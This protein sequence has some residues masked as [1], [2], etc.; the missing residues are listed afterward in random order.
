MNENNITLKK[1]YDENP[2]LAKSYAAIYSYKSNATSP[3]LWMHYSHEQLNAH[4]T[5]PHMGRPWCNMYI[6]LSGNFSFLID[7]HMYTP[8]FGDIVIFRDYENYTTIFPEASYVDYYQIYFPSSFFSEASTGNL[9]MTP[10]YDRKKAERNL[11]SPSKSRHPELIGHLQALDDIYESPNEYS[12]ILMYS[13]II[14]IM[15]LVHSTF[16]SESAFK[17]NSK[18]PQKLNDAII[19]IHNSFKTIDGVRELC[20]VCNVSNVYLTRV[21]NTYLQCTPNEY[22]TN[23]R[24][25]HAKYLL[26]IGKSITEACFESGFNNYTY[27]ISKFKSV[28]GLTPSKFRKEKK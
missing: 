20:K 24:I 8:R 3:V 19:Y 22:I 1:Y 4:H 25:S 12:D 17:S 14:Q 27:F 10:F 13:H 9:F 23:L 28:T 6:F 15:D 18:I 5:S 26:M 2:N 16:I 21:F 7:G 11:I